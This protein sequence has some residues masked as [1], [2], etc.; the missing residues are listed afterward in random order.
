[1]PRGTKNV[2][3]VNSKTLNYRKCSFKEGAF[4]LTQTEFSIIC[5]GKKLIREKYP[6]VINRNI[7]S[8]N[9]TCKLYFKHNR[10]LK[11][12]DSFKIYA[13]CAHTFCKKFILYIRNISQTIK[14]KH[15]VEVFSSGR[16]FN[17]LK[18][19]STQLRGINRKLLKRELLNVK[20][21]EQRQN[22]VLSLDNKSLQKFNLG[23]VKSDAVYRKARCEAFAKNDRH[24]DDLIDMIETQRDHHNYI[25][26]VGIPFHVYIYSSEQLSLLSLRYITVLHL[27]ATGSIVRRPNTSSKKV[28]YYAGVIQIRE[29]DRLCPVVEMISCEHDGGSIGAWLLKFRSFCVSHNKWPAFKKVVTDSR[30]CYFKCCLYFFQ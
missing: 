14:P 20:A 10:Y 7:V 4:F 9:N 11:K 28:Y 23:E 6:L 13:Y 12:S 2:K 25:Q 27:D 22:D 17:H 24:N 15:K 18:N 3:D 16:D 26:S 21:S 8:V 5:K 30:F 19:V 29:S 1:M